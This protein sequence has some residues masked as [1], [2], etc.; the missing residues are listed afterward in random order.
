[1]SK[2]EKILD[3]V[4]ENLMIYRSSRL[5]WRWIRLYCLSASSQEKRKY[6]HCTW[7]VETYSGILT[8]E[9][10]S[11]PKRPNPHLPV[12]KETKISHSPPFYF[13]QK[14]KKFKL[15]CNVIVDNSFLVKFKFC[16]IFMACV[17]LKKAVLRNVIN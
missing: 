6:L 13:H 11:M 3:N 2:E 8:C 7:P 5:E 12:T 14:K 15:Y 17:T 9:S 10:I 16:T 1:M 4:N